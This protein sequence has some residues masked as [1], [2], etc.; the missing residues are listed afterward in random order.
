MGDKIY[1]MT[2]ADG[3]VLEN[4]LING[5]NYISKT[6]LTEEDF[7]YKLAKVTVSDGEE[8]IVYENMKLIQIMEMPTTR[9]IPEEQAGWWFVLSAM[10]PLELELGRMKADIE[11]LSMMT[12]VEL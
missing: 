6:L 4:L 2:L 10:S 5:N 9:G 3:T 11:Y 12:D 1:T 7:K 8:E